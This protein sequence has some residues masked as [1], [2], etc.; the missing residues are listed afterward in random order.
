MVAFTVA[1]NCLRNLKPLTVKLKK[2]AKDIVQAYS[3]IRDVT[4]CISTI[5]QDIDTVFS[6][7]FGVVKG[8]AQTLSTEVT[9]PRQAA[10]QTHRDNHLAT[11]PEPQAL[12]SSVLHAFASSTLR[13]FA[14]SSGP[15]Q[16][17]PLLSVYLLMRLRLCS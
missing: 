11:N 5:R 15:V 10:R 1:C 2:K 6:P 9:V 4:T 7:W 17:V 13:A 14:P 8:I 16:H 3:E 12:D